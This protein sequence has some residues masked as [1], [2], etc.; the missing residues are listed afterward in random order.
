MS[1]LLGIDLGAT[2]V[3]AAALRGATGEPM[4]PA[5]ISL[6]ALL[7]AT[8]AGDLL[9]GSAARRRAPAEPDR[10]ARGFL[11]RVGDPTPLSLGGIPYLAEDLCARL[12]RVVVDEMGARHGGPPSRIG[13]T[14]PVSW[15]RHKRDL[16]AA[17]LGRRGLTVSL[18]AAP[19]A[20]GLAR[21]TD[22]PAAGPL[23]VVDLGGN[24]STAT[25]LAPAGP[26]VLPEILGRTVA[27]AAGGADV[28]D[29]VFGF[30]RGATPALAAAFD[31]LDVDDPRVLAALRV[32]RDDCRAA[33][34]LLSRDTV[35]GV[36]VDLPGIRTTVR[37]HRSDLDEL[38]GPVLEPVADLLADVAAAA[39][40]AEVLLAGGAARTPVAVQ[41]LSARLGR[42]VAV[43]ADPVHDAARGAALAVAP[44]AGT[45]WPGTRIAPVP[46]AV[47]A[48]RSGAPGAVLPA[49]RAGAA[50]RPRGGRVRPERIGSAV[51][52]LA[53]NGPANGTAPAVPGQR[54]MTPAQREAVPTQRDMTPAQ[55]DIEAALV[56]TAPQRS[57]ATPVAPAVA[58]A[59]ATRADPAVLPGQPDTLVT[60]D[61]VGRPATRVLTRQRVLIGAGGLA[62]A[63]AVA[64]ALLF[65]PSS[66]P[67]LGELSAAP[68]LPSTSAPAPSPVPP[69][70]AAAPV[71]GAAGPAAADA[72]VAA[73]TGSGAPAASTGAPARAAGTAAPARPGTAAPV[74]PAPAAPVTPAPV[75]PPPAPVPSA[76]VPPAPNPSSPVE[77]PASGEAEPSA[78]V[79]PAPDVTTPPPTTT[80]SP[81]A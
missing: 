47:P 70:E 79:P 53:P 62:G 33:K 36:P 19:Q 66:S 78:S 6:P 34:E 73:R 80:V 44:G 64:G 56:R 28:D 71:P 11:N 57:A 65:W 54:D 45:S 25:V 16:L 46:A 23:A 7:V 20:V 67:T 49:R 13:I 24:G 22:V 48:P 12:V 27:C 29:A 37:I 30:V 68:T 40:D 58:P 18:V 1:Y 50:H 77:T 76:P 59:A 31:E 39:P 5:G 14:H 17:A 9:C 55:H 8:P 69:P 10:V 15:G 2:A 35:A 51:A 21:R 63:L 38:A 52:L 61:P 72:A 26:G 43:T 74:A 60:R 41:L 75:A 42:P 4:R 81:T 3:T 32:L